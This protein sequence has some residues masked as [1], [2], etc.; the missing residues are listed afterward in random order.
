MRRSEGLPRS[1]LEHEQGLTLAYGLVAEAMLVAVGRIGLSPLALPGRQATRSPLGL[2]PSRP[3]LA[4]L[5][6]GQPVGDLADQ[7]RSA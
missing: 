4:P 5:P 3:G 2:A 7:R 6:T 1:V